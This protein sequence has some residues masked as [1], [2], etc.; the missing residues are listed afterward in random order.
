MSVW[1]ILVLRGL[2]AQE[3][4]QSNTASAPYA[5]GTGEAVPTFVRLQEETAVAGSLRSAH[6]GHAQ[7]CLDPGTGN[8]GG[9]TH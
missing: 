5:Q 3:Q 2:M 8:G 6:C 7:P 1:P 9:F 4:G